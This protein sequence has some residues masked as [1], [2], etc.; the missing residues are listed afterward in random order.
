MAACDK[1]AKLRRYSCLLV[2]SGCAGPCPS[3][4]PDRRYFRRVPARRDN[5]YLWSL[6]INHGHFNMIQHTR[7]RC[8]RL[9]HSNFSALYLREPGSQCL[10]DIKSQRLDQ[11]ALTACD[12]ILNDGESD[13]VMYG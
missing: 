1:P 2:R 10:G 3:K 8:V 6:R 9:A 11:I 12:D 5:V 4:Q 7:N 13:T